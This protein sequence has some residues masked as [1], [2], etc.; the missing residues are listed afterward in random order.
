MSFLLALIY[1]LTCLGLVWTM[2][3]YRGL[4]TTQLGVLAIFSLGYYP[5]PV[6]FQPISSLA[7]IS[8]DRI[9]P[10]LL[11]HWLFLL[12]ILA[13]SFLSVGVR[14]SIRPLT[15]G[16]VD[17]IAQRYRPFIA[18]CAFGTYL[19][20]SSTVTQTSYAAEDFDAYF[21][22][23]S[24]LASI[25]SAFTGLCDAFV[26]LSFASAVTDKD[27]SQTILYGA[28]MTVM[29]LLQLPLGQRLA[30]LTPIVM[31]FAAMACA[32]QFKTAVR[33]LG[34]AVLILAIV[35]PFAVFLREARRSLNGEFLSASEVAGKFQV[36][37][38]PL[39]QSFE[40]IVDRS[41]L[42]Y[43]T[44]FMKE[45]IDRTEY[46]GWQYYYS[47]LVSPIPR[48]IYPEKPYVLS[49]T[50]NLDGEI[51][52]LS[53]QVM[54]GGLGSLTAF[55]GLTAYRE[56]GWLAVLI[57]GVAA[58]GLFVFVARWLGEGSL[59]AKMFYVMFFSRFFVAK[60][61]ASF[62]E[63]LVIILGQASVVAILILASMALGLLMR[64]RPSLAR[65]L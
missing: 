54:I 14:R 41:D 62:F 24:N 20:Y 43:N 61:P 10:A 38:N 1:L 12:S 33:V 55:G 65:R 26:A 45:Y 32:K 34:V 37:D 51:S 53:W 2:V 35:S 15:F 50:G 60:A 11:V 56:G 40:S 47:A 39:L 57:D 5:L 19:L 48:V 7:G 4:V 58:G 52:V 36:S 49:S 64:S 6:L 63:S 13:G 21:E 17:G 23:S 44:V 42:V 29:V 27:R 9:F 16:V 18:W 30:V 31:L 8:D 25:L 3:K 46:V 28:M 22:T 59:L